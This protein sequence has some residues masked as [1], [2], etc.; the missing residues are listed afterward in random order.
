MKKA[1]YEIIEASKYYGRHATGVVLLR[2]GYPEFHGSEEEAR[3]LKV[4]HSMPDRKIK[5]PKRKRSPREA[6]YNSFGYTVIP[7]AR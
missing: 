1:H 6:M 3:Q 2:N 7:E 5:A 4:I